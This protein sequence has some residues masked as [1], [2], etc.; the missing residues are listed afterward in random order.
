MITLLLA[1]AVIF[2]LFFIYLGI[3]AA[4]NLKLCTLCAAVS[5]T[6]VFLIVLQLLGKDVSAYLVTL[7]VG[8]STLGIF[9]AIQKVRN[10][11]FFQL[12]IY[13]TITTTA[14]ALIATVFEQTMQYSSIAT[15]LASTW[16]LFAIVHIYRKSRHFRT[17]VKRIT[18]C[19]R[20]N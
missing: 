13:F 4:T 5:S 10:I 20:R 16:A 7:L 17:I 6:W 11:E 3:K 2:A 9:Y 19:C 15:F 8:Q 1:L 14:Y 12:P 18:E